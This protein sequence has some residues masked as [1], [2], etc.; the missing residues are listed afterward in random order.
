MIAGKNTCASVRAPAQATENRIGCIKPIHNSNLYFIIAAIQS[1]T[2]HAVDF[3]LN[4]QLRNAPLNED[5][6]KIIQSLIYWTK[7]LKTHFKGQ[8]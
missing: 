5:K 2:F 4:R 8:R 7:C 3:V 6:A 1:Q